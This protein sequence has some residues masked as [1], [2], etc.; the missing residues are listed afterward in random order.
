MSNIGDPVTQTIP[1]VGT[2]GTSYATDINAL[3]TEFKSRLENKVPLS[4][5]LI[6]TLDLTNNPLQ[7]AQYLSLYP[8][9]AAPTTPTGSLQMYAGNLYWVSSS[10]AV[11]ITN[12]AL[13]NS[14]SIGG[15]TGDYGGTNPA[16]FRF[17]DADQTYYAYDDFS[18]NT[19]A[20]FRARDIEIAGGAT[21]ANRVRIVWG[22]SVNYTLT[23]PAALPGTQ[24]LLQLTS[25]GTLTASGV[26]ATDESITLSGT[27]RVLTGNRDISQGLY[28]A[29]V[30]VGSLSTGYA[31][32][33]PVFTA[34]AN[35]VFYIPLL[36]LESNCRLLS[37]TLFSNAAS[38]PTI[39]LFA[40]TGST[41]VGGTSIASTQSSATSGAFRR[42]IQTVD[43]P[44]ARIGPYYYIK[45]TNIA[46]IVDYYKITIVY[47]TV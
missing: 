1:A 16:Q 24:K 33:N 47:D 6:G 19:W 2:T 11:Q 28:N 36:G 20:H 29:T 14:S 25:T 38:N 40:E 27:G 23:L 43:V 18:T 45:V 8:Q 41:I 34:A 7:N 3:L 32:D 13:L 22:G 21:S 26:L 44:V 15:I 4:S 30:T 37:V 46:A 9:P 35:S 10:G 5:L 12:G 42:T 17:V 31:A 39:V